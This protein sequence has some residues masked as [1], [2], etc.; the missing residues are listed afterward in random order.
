MVSASPLPLAGLRVLDLNRFAPGLFATMLLGDMGADVLR[1]EEVAP[2]GEGTVFG[3]YQ[4]EKAK[5]SYALNRNKRSI[6]L[7]LK[8][9]E[10]RAIFYA[11]ADEA[12]VVVEGYRPGVA[13]RLGIDYETLAARNERLIYCALS[14]YGQT[15]PYA[16]LVGHDV[17]YLAVAGAL[18]ITG[19]R[20]G[21]PVI[22]GF[23]LADFAGGGL[24]AALGILLALE[25]R[26]KTGRGQYVDIAMT[27]GTVAVIAN[28][29]SSFFGGSPPPERG[30]ALTSGG[31][32]SYNVYECADGKYLSLGM[33]EPWFWANLCRALGRDDLLD[34][35]FVTGAERDAVEA[36][37]AA[38]FRT[39]TRDEWF[40]LL[41]ERDVC[42]APVYSFDELSNDP[43]LRHREMI[44]DVPLPGGGTVRQPGIAIKLSDTPGRIR[45]LPPRPG[46]HTDEVLTALGYDAARIAALR[47][48]GVVR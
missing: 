44:V 11:L 22:P 19:V 42:V 6:C 39:R 24:L 21:P 13:R 41:R 4:A 8:A 5:P 30:N 23:Q 46:Q 12:D 27:D 28:L 48:A 40:V 34:K 37:L 45:S 35:Q 38:L 7:N 2:P 43:Q 25:A 10:G 17:N 18:G 20:G 33:L 29:L 15:G 31:L 1:V 26:H 47:A 14:G 3:A 32:P 36:E 9:P 16:N